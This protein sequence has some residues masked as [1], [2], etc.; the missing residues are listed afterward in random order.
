MGVK[1]EKNTSPDMELF[2]YGIT[3]EEGDKLS[4]RIYGDNYWDKF[5]N[6]Y[7]SIDYSFNY[8]ERRMRKSDRGNYQYII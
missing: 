1:V 5:Y 7:H 3:S 8:E 6:F 4:E 2:F